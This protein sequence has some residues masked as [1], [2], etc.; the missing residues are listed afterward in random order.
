MFYPPI[1]LR[2]SQMSSGPRSLRDAPADP[3]VWAPLDGGE[4]LN[5]LIDMSQICLDSPHPAAASFRSSSSLIS[6]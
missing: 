5:E 6:W 1:L 4:C 2:V 3:H